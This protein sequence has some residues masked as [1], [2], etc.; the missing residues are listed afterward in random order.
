VDVSERITV[1]QSGLNVTEDFRFTRP[2]EVV[3]LTG[4]LGLQFTATGLLINGDVVV[5]V[6]A[7]IFARLHVS[8]ETQQ[9]A[10]HDNSPLTAD[11]LQALRDLFVGI[12][13]FFDFLEHLLDPLED[14]IA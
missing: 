2:G 14:L 8:G 5:T 3:R 6:N 9:W 1:S 10:K 13:R 7:G 4:N 11:E 12:E